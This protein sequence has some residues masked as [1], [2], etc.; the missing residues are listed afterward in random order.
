[1]SLKRGVKQMLAEANAE[2]DT[3]SVH[4][5]VS[6]LDD[7]EVV[8]VDIRE[9]VERAQG[10]VP[11]SAHAPRAFLEFQAD[12]ESDAHNKVFSSG[13]RLLLFCRSGGRSALAA[14]TLVDMGVPNVAHIA[15]GFAAWEAAKAPVDKP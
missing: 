4:D 3:V 6:L 5:A 9:H 12:P 13:K 1:M 2:I 8:F 15:G 10:T 11:G 14:K 7:P